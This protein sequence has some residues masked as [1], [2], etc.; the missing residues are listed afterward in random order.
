[1]GDLSSRYLPDMSDSYLLDESSM[2]LEEDPSDASFSFPMPATREVRG[3]QADATTDMSFDLPASS[4]DNLLDD[5]GDDFFGAADETLGTPAPPRA[6]KPMGTP[7]LNTAKKHTQTPR[8]SDGPLTLSQLT[9]R[10]PRWYPDDGNPDDSDDDDNDDEES[11]PLPAMKTRHDDAQPMQSSST[12]AYNFDESFTDASSFAP[13]ANS[14]FLSDADMSLDP[15]ATRLLAYSE[16]YGLYN[17]P[18]TASQP[19]PSPLQEERAATPKPEPPRNDEP[20]TI[21]QLSPRKATPPPPPAK[22]PRPVKTPARTPAAARKARTPA[23]TF[24][25]PPPAQNTPTPALP[26]IQATP[27]PSVS[28]LPVASS[29]PVPAPVLLEAAPAPP[30]LMSKLERAPSPM[31]RSGKRQ[32]TAREEDEEEDQ[33]ERDEGAECDQHDDEATT[34]QTA[35]PSRPAPKKAPAATESRRPVKRAK[36]EPVVKRGLNA[37]RNAQKSGITERRRVPSG[38]PVRG[39]PKRAVSGGA[40]RA[41][42]AS[43]RVASATGTLR[44]SR[45]TNQVT[46]VGGSKPTVKASAKLASQ[47]AVA[48]KRENTPAAQMHVKPPVKKPSS[49]V[50]NDGPSTRAIEE[51]PTKSVDSLGSE[52]DA[53]E[54]QDVLSEGHVLTEGE[55]APPSSADEPIITSNSPT[56]AEALMVVDEEAPALPFESHGSEDSTRGAVE[57]SHPISDDSEDDEPASGAEE[58]REPMAQAEAAAAPAPSKPQP[59]R[60]RQARAKQRPET[61]KPPVTKK[62]PES[63][64][65]LQAKKQPEVKKQTAKKAPEVKKTQPEF[66]KQAEVKRQPEAKKPFDASCAPS[67]SDTSRPFV[68]GTGKQFKFTSSTSSESGSSKALHASEGS[69]HARSLSRSALNVSVTEPKPFQF[70]TDVRLREREAFDA[71]VKERLRR[72]EEEE[73]ERRRQAEME[74]EQE[75]KQLRKRMVPRAHDVPEW[76]RSAPKKKRLEE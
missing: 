60:S 74:A 32:S 50:R 12:A 30:A 15:A 21:S 25:A 28:P 62:Q 56:D 8:K 33:E 35:G 53:S 26:P 41:V 63:K 61:K 13:D 11:S 14:T 47:T 24:T 40:P 48:G 76:Y 71:K 5:D 55:Q 20:L 65:Q 38:P 2:Q 75:V 67:T 44:N 66:K 6:A 39:P 52:E 58:A 29:S 27:V 68:F 34:A 49:V 31:K 72:E 73:A 46:A 37:S 57:P 45:A 64:K 70:H 10:A 69:T 4:H 19:T 23:P 18:A 3:A 1:M 59:E 54:V 17:N 22:T 36:I 51:Q 9:P 7:R 43:A 42:S 16:E